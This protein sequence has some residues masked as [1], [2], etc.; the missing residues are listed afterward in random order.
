MRIGFTDLS[1]RKNVGAAATENIPA[2]ESLMNRRRV[3][4]ILSC[5]V[6]R[7]SKYPSAERPRNFAGFFDSARN[8][9]HDAATGNSVN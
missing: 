8:D 1:A 6:K 3:V 2:V 9:A 4:F 5:Y 7:E